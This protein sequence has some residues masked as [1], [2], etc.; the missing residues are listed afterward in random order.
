MKNIALIGFMG[1]GKTT[2]AGL[3]ADA[4]HYNLCE[5]DNDI[6]G[7]SGY[8]SVNEIFDKQGEE[9]FRGLEK[10]A[11]ADALRKSNQVI[12]CGGGVVTAPKTMELLK[13]NAIV[14]FLQADFK[15]ITKRLKDTTSR[16]LFRDME[17]AMTLYAERLPL[18]E[19]Y[20][21]I[22]IDTDDRS[23]EEIAKMI[24]PKLDSYGK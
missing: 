2:L 10:I 16:P 7:I 3:L 8:S 6:I 18:Y 1:S 12:S 9:H 20:A 19:K 22:K 11:I 17:K 5:V 23:P 21:D 4:L 24:L 13:K 15:T 14:V